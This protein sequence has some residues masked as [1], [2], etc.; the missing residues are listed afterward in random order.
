MEDKTLKLIL[1]SLQDNQ[2]KTIEIKIDLDNM[3]ADIIELKASGEEVKK[4]LVKRQEYIDGALEKKQKY[5]DEAVNKH[6]K[7]ITNGFLLAGLAIL[8]TSVVVLII[9]IF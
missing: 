5:L 3:K 2:E 1:T 6:E 4:D 7:R 9:N 8:I